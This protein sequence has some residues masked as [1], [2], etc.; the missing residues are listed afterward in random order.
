MNCLLDTHAL[1]WFLDGDD[2]LSAT[3]RQIIED[4]NNSMWVSIASLWEIAIKLSIGKLQLNQPFDAL[5]DEL[6]KNLIGLLPLGFEHTRRVSTLPFHHRDPFDRML[7][8]QAMT[9]NLVVVSRD[10]VF[11]AYGISREW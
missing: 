2:R 4:L 1:L 6:N 10:A 7:I 9:E 5:Q 3:A 11:D 8:A